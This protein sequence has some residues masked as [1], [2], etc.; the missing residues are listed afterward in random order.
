[1]LTKKDLLLLSFLR[2]NARQK[3]TSISR[4]TGIPV[5]TM[6]DAL[7]RH[8]KRFISKHSSLLKFGEIGFNT[9]IYAALKV[10]QSDK[11]KLQSFL[12]EHSN[13]NSLYR[14]NNGFDFLIEALFKD[15]AEAEFFIGELNSR[16]SLLDKKVFNV[17]CDIEKEKFLT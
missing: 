3:I 11:E 9:K 15:K 10:E 14:I 17:A 16:F 4:K 7:R 2:K 6:Y 8:E 12:Q 1:M 13:T 5:T